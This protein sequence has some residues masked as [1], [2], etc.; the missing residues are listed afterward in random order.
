MD[1][2]RQSS[3]ADINTNPVGGVNP[4]WGMDA[5]LYRGMHNSVIINILYQCLLSFFYDI[6]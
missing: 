4:Y 6:T 1:V 3:N 2:K 5:N